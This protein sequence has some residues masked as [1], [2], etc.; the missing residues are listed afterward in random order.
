MLNVKTRQEYLNAIGIGCGAEDGIWGAKCRTATLALQKRYFPHYVGGV[1]QHD[2]KYGP[3]TD[4]LLQ[5]AYN[6]RGLKYFKLEEFRCKCG[7]EYCN[8]YPAVVSRTLALKLN[9]TLRPKYGAITIVSGLRCETWNRKQG[10]VAGSRH[11]LGKAADFQCALSRKSKDERSKIIAYCKRHFRY[12][13]G[14]TAGMGA[15][16][17]VDVS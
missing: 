2:G 8:G 12:C 15:S 6:C 1:N 10:G 5:S 4:I 11:R 13:Y 3:K 17:H 9:Q 16:V 7:G 14:N